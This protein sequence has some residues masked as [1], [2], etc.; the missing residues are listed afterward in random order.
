MTY[1][2]YPNPQPDNQP[3]PG[4][5]Q[6]PPAPQQSRAIGITSMVL[7]ILAILL[8]FIPIIGVVSFLLGLAAIGLGIYAVVKVKG[9]GQGIAGII[10]GALGV[11]VALVVTLIT[12]AIFS[13]IEEDMQNNPE[14]YENE[15]ED[16]EDFEDMMEN[17]GSENADGS[18]LPDS[19]TAYSS[20]TIVG[21][22]EALPVGEDGEVSVVAIS[23]AEDSPMFP[24]IVQNQTD[25]AVSSIKVSG[26]AYD[27]DDQT[28]G[29]GSSYSTSP[30]VVLPGEYAFGYL[31]LD[32]SERD[33]PEGV[34]IPDLK[35]DYTEGLESYESSVA[36]DIENFEEL[37][38]GDITG[39]VSNPH[40]ID[41]HVPVSV[42]TLCVT[43]DES[44]IYD[45]TYSDNDTLTAGDTSTWTLSYYDDAPDC[46][47]RMISAVGRDNG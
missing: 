2:P 15:L 43:S 33:L 34:T 3:P 5:Y 23:Q 16:L 21:D 30:H 20:L 27:G 11:I 13:V 14:Y 6:Q 17:T 7:G 24:F 31:Y 44:L 38:S 45:N 18:G 4:Y 8:A 1:E 28:L 37:S 26:R 47:I 39:D 46:A 12:G 29:S 10:T 9:K 40:E 41:V 19:P 42:D 36:V 32:T 35:I 22:E 25:Q